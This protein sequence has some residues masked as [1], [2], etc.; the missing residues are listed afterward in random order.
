MWDGTPKA[1]KPTDAGSGKR[2]GG[3]LLAY[4]CN[5]YNFTHLLNWD[6]CSPDVEIQWVVLKLRYTRPIYIA[7]VYRPPSGNVDNA[8]SLIE[9][10]VLDIS[11][12]CPGDIIIMGDT[13][14]DILDKTD[15]ITKRYLNFFKQFNV[16]QL[17]STPTRIGL[18]KSSLLDHALTNCEEMYYQHGSIDYGLSDHAL[19]YTPRKRKK[20]DHKV[21]RITH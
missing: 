16:Q 5:H 12:N 13:N 20:L 15:V 2:G 8:L 4:S 14:I 3:G 10:K 7:N 9:N 1:I 21:S 19:I 11:A 18:T 6:L 17:I